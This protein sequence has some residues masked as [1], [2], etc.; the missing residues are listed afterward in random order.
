MVNIKNAFQHRYEIIKNFS[1]YSENKDS[2]ITNILLK[3]KDNKEDKDVFMDIIYEHIN[4]LMVANIFYDLHYS[5]IADYKNGYAVVCK[6]NI[7]TNSDLFGFI[8]KKGEEIIEPKFDF[9]FSFKENGLAI[10]KKEGKFGFLKNSGHYL[11]EPIF[12]EVKN[13][14]GEQA[15]VKID[16]TWKCINK[17]GHYV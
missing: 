2:Y 9:A 12:D 5:Y 16:N 11:L 3:L 4:T 10:V 17:R 15:E 1:I 13:F 6:T 7:N 8:N 14:I